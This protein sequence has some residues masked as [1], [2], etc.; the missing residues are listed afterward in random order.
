[1]GLKMKTEALPPAGSQYDE[2]LGVQDVQVKPVQAMTSVELG[3]GKG[4]FQTPS[5]SQD[6]IP[7]QFETYKEFAIGIEG[8]RTINLGDYNSCRIGV[9][10]NIP[11]HP[12]N[13]EQAYA[14]GLEWIGQK[15][16]TEVNAIQGK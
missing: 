7:G 3:A 14:W 1:M 8:S 15:I 9:S 16:M 11:C 2:H 12:K 13:A 5:E 4:K 10:L 6:V